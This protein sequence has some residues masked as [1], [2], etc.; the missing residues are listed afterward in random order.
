MIHELAPSQGCLCTV[1]MPAVGPEDLS[2]PTVGTLCSPGFPVNGLLTVV[3]RCDLLHKMGLYTP[4][5]DNT[6][7][8]DLNGELDYFQLLHSQHHLLCAFSLCVVVSSHPR[9]RA[10][11][12]V[13]VM[14]CV[15]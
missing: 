6:I 10:P 12:S 7:V 11:W 14:S 2:P 3:M 1:V 4:Q 8:S 5:S 9:L 13:G 15:S